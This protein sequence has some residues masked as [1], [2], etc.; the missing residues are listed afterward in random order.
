MLIASACVFLFLTLA[1][2]LFLPRLHLMARNSSDGTRVSLLIPV[3]NESASLLRTAATWRKIRHPNLEILVLDDGSSDNSKSILR[4]SGFEVISGLPL[5]EGWTG[6][7]WACHQL[8]ERASGEIFIFA[9]A[10]VSTSEWAINRT[11]AAMAKYGAQALSALPFQELNTALEKIIIPLFLHVPILTWVPVF[12]PSRFLPKSMALGNGQWFAI[13]RD[14][15]RKIG[16]H[17]EIRSS[18]IDDISL[19]KRLRKESLNT[20]LALAPQDLSVRMYRSRS[21]LWEG[22]T[23]NL[24]LIYGGS[25]R[26]LVFFALLFFVSQIAPLFHPV[27]AILWITSRLFCMACVQRNFISILGHPF[28]V[29]IFYI[30]LFRSSIKLARGTATWKGRKIAKRFKS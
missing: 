13:R 16:G 21:Q 5:P 19:A 9:D 25:L 8:A 18:P 10:D 27:T 6:K 29:V 2:F 7:N 11:L 3:R 26:R 23:K 30:L 28:G 15:Y 14:A 20:I 24:A 1:N 22:F 12:L 4:E 17:A